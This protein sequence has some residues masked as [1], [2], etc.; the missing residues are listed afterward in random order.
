MCASD[1]GDAMFQ[2]RLLISVGCLCALAAFAAS[3]PELVPMAAQVVFVGCLAI[4]F[5][6]LPMRLADA[7]HAGQD[8]AVYPN[9]SPANQ[10]ATANAG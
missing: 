5:G 8:L 3:T 2:H 4:F 9:A 6:A 1:G 7:G 10:M